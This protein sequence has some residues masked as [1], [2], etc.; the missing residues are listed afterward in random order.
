MI[1]YIT[2]HYRNNSPPVNSP[3]YPCVVLAYD[4]WDDYTFKTSFVMSYYSAHG[5]SAIEIGLVKIFYT[6]NKSTYEA[7]KNYTSGIPKLSEQYCSLGQSI[8]YYRNLRQLP[9]NAGT[10]IL[11]LLR[12]IAFDANIRTAF[13]NYDGVKVSLLRSLG[14]NAVLKNGRAIF[15]GESQM[16]DEMDFT[17]STK[18]PKADNK[19]QLHVVFKSNS[20]LPV[21]MNII[22]GRNGTGKTSFLGEFAKSLVDS[23]SKTGDFD[24]VPLA[25]CVIA[26]SYNAFDNF[27]IPTSAESQRINYFYCGLRGNNALLFKTEVSNVDITALDS[28][29]V[30]SALEPFFNSYLDGTTSITTIEKTRKWEISDKYTKL[31]LQREGTFLHCYGEKLLTFKEQYANVRNNLDAIIRE[32][33]NTKVSF[34]SDLLKI[35]MPSDDQAEAFLSDTSRRWNIYNNMSAG[36]RIISGMIA[37]V[38]ANIKENSILLIDEPENHLH[39]GLLS[40]FMAIIEKILD[41]F[42][43]YAIIATHSPLILQQVP[44]SSVTIFE[45]NKNRVSWRHPDFECFGESQQTISEMALDLAE[46]ELDFHDKLQELARTKTSA[47]INSIFNDRLGFSARLYLESL[48]ALATE[49]K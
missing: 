12:D 44:S 4:T 9:Q 49:S 47:E 30:P 23:N 48:K 34:I 39:P 17:F 24:G 41:N 10:S 22:I 7:L 40:S 36:Q 8:D 38:C 3:T 13:E 29:T 28:V 33:D 32:I 35:I 14:A 15:L 26:I 31:R 1:F 6:G 19:H 18:L 46:P 21:R 16:F 43:S 25:Q 5:A 20:P 2:G 11:I 27:D 45:R 42:S 37:A